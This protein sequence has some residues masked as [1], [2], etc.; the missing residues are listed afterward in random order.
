MTPD[1]AQGV[2][3]ELSFVLENGWTFTQVP[4]GFRVAPPADFQSRADY[5][6]L[7]RSEVWRIVAIGRLR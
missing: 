2:A 6:A 7:F 4:D 5:K 3:A 1:T